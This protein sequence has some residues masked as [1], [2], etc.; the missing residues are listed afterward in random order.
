MCSII[1]YCGPVADMAA[2]QAGFA[3]T[4]S[5]GP[6][7]SR[8]VQA[9]EGLL[10][11]H[12][13]AIMGLSPE[14]MQP[15][16]LNGALAVCNGEIY[17]FRSLKNQLQEKGYVFQ[18]DSDC[19]ILL[20]LYQEYGL[21]MFSRLDAEFAM[22][23]YDGRSGSL[24]AARDPIGIRP[25]YYGYD[26]AGTILFASE[27]KNLLGLTD[28]VMPFPPGH[29]YRG[30]KFVCYHDIAKVEHFCYDELENTVAKYG[31]NSGTAI[32]NLIDTPYWDHVLMPL[33]ERAIVEMFW[34]IVWF[35]DKDAKN[36]TNGGI[37]TE[38]V[39]LELLN[40]CDGLFKQLKGIASANPGQFTAIAANEE[41]TYAAQK[42][43][44]RVPGVA[45]GIVDEMLSDCD[46]RIFDDEQAAIY[47]T[48]GLFKALRNDVKK[49]QNLHL[50]V[51]QICS[52]IQM[53]EYDGHPL[54]ILDVWDRLIK[55]FENDG[56]KLNAPY[57]ALISTPNNLFVGTDDKQ[58]VAD[59]SVHFDDTDRMNYIFAQSNI[60]TLVGE[61]AL[62]HLAM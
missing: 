4:K 41:S 15:F 47:M 51:S 26:S 50:E 60:G 5:R 16:A 32:G 56:T 61:D 13:L 36:I 30:G 49:V 17:G 6:D 3:R 18:S 11:F 22:V 28:K 55:K 21:E 45:I 43:A 37:I 35:G 39:D 57:R 59:L 48:N 23:I 34:R 20:P 8:T 19:E 27:P 10:G 14:G 7:D 9:G 62:T 12:R 58:R 54:I 38:T 29:Y 40:M 46:S 1:G 31:M 2:L 25:L 33:L 52:G 53:S 44:I 24:V 42:A